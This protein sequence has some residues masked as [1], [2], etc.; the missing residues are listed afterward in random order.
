MLNYLFEGSYR[1]QRNFP[2]SS[3]HFY[4][5]TCHLYIRPPL[6]VHLCS[7]LRFL[8][9]REKERKSR[10]EVEGQAE[11]FFKGKYLL[12]LYSPHILWLRL[13]V[14]KC[15]G[16][17]HTYTHKR[18][19]RLAGALIPPCSPSCWCG[20]LWGQPLGGAFFLLVAAA[21]IN[22][23][24]FSFFFC[25]LS[26][27]TRWCFMKY[28]F[29]WSRWFMNFMAHWLRRCDRRDSGESPMTSAALSAPPPSPQ[30]HHHIW[31][32]PGLKFDFSSFGFF[33][34]T[35]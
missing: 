28:F 29:K 31:P 30:Q 15:E 5:S 33:T 18:C 24:A 13:S 20:E 14:Q 23:K 16:G 34:W 2:A 35:G 8:R 19:H 26:G 27:F 22:G 25:F 6:P 3:C 21:E 12:R 4:G 11:L 17:K 10:R 32:T 1:N 7:P 9:C